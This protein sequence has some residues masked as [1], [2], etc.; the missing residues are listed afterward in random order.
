MASPAAGLRGRPAVSHICQNRA[1]MGHPA[2][3][4]GIRRKIAAASRFGRD[5]HDGTVS[6]RWRCAVPTGLLRRRPL[7]SF[8]TEHPGLKSKPGRGCGLISCRA[9]QRGEKNARYLLS[10]VVRKPAILCVASTDSGSIASYQ[11][12]C[13][14]PSKTTRRASTPACRKARCRLVAPLSR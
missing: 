12:A 8:P 10:C 3:V 2:V 13:G 1:D 6:I 11:K 4:A 14:K 9:G 5:D 7:K